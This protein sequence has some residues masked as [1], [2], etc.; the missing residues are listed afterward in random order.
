MSQNTF[1]SAPAPA[2][3]VSVP[4]QESPAENGRKRLL[5][6]GI[7]GM[8]AAVLVVGGVIV[9]GG[10]DE[11]V[12]STVPPS[13][14]APIV[15]P[16]A[17]TTPPASVPTLATLN[18][19]N[20]FEPQI[21][22]GTGSAAPEAGGS[23][24]VG[25]QPTS[26]VSGGSRSVPTTA[27]VPGPQVTRTLTVEIPGP[28]TTRVVKVPVPGPTVY[29]EPGEIEVVYLGTTA[30]MPDPSVVGQLIPSDG[31][32]ADFTVNGVGVYDVAVPE[33][34]AEPDE[35]STFAY[36]FSLVRHDDD[37][38]VVQFGEATRRILVDR[39]TFF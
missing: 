39:P 25:P 18:G 8:A 13:P 11:V 24:T 12:G 35:A 1:G 20:P 3:V 27:F 2:E 4:A 36:Y 30:Q 22:V 16:S 19:R 33:R 32:L 26:N 14:A 7:A 28:V 15:L 17:T 37:S 6:A 23:A 9:L 21:V 10:D 31:N 38:A 5:I 29:L 34:T